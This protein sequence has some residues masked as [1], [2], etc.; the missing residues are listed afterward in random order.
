MFGGTPFLDRFLDPYGVM[1]LGAQAYSAKRSATYLLSAAD[2][3]ESRVVEHFAGAT[4]AA[5]A[6]ADAALR[7][8]SC[9]AVTRRLGAL[10]PTGLARG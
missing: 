1:L 10:G 4:M 9:V 5:V 6:N 3:A 2:G 7:C 8:E